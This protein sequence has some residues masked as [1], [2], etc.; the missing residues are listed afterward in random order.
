LDLRRR[1]WGDCG[2]TGL[3]EGSGELLEFRQRLPFS[4]ADGLQLGPGIGAALRN[5]GL[6]LIRANRAVFFLIGA[7]ELER[8]HERCCEV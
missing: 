7:K 5:P 8:R 3:L 6:D 4:G 2:S 1:G